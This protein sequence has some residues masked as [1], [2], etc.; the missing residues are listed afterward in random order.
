[1]SF[2][3]RDTNDNRF[4]PLIFKQEQH[5]IPIDWL[6]PAA[7]QV[8][9]TLYNA[10]FQAYVVGGAVRD[11]ILSRRPKD[12]DIVS[13]ATAS[14][15][16]QLFPDAIQMDAHFHYVMQML[17]GE[18]IEISTFRR[19]STD[20]TS[21][22]DAPNFAGTIAEDAVQRDFT[23]NSLYYDPMQRE[24]IDWHDGVVDLRKKI[25]RPI[26]DPVSRFSENPMSMLRAIRF[27][28]TLGFSISP[29]AIAAMHELAPLMTQ[30]STG[31]VLAELK[32]HLSSG[33][34]L[35]CMRDI[36]RMGLHEKLLPHLAEDL[37]GESD[38]TFL[39]RALES[40]DQSV[41]QCGAMSIEFLF[42]IILWPQVRLQWSHYRTKGDTNPRAIWRAGEA[43][44]CSQAA[45]LKLGKQ[46]S[47]DMNIIWSTQPFFE[48]P[49]TSSSHALLRHSRFRAGYNLLQI[50]CATGEL[51]AK[52]GAWWVNFFTDNVFSQ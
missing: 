36:C 32:R 28:H 50:R 51:D 1:M 34:A 29:S 17:Y 47:R 25:I 41:S 2:S 21:Y 19:I 24:V 8:C 45:T 22:R 23:I 9:L 7:Q 6:S 49:T 26:G 43:I 11:I 46:I 39:V 27:K 18:C 3:R 48:E 31:R 13:D 5:G 33:N 42:A 10:G 44:L 52:L 40:V 4:K 37:G 38:A 15:L 30:V 20:I 14:Q 35:A 16:L 12:F